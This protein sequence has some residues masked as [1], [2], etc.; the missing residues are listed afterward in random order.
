VLAFEALTRHDFSEFDIIGNAVEKR[1]YKLADYNYRSRFYD[2]MILSLWYGGI[3]WK[4]RALFAT[5]SLLRA[6]TQKQLGSME[7]ALAEVCTR[8]KVDILAV[9]NLAQC[10]DVPLIFAEFTDAEQVTYYTELF[11]KVIGDNG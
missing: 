5:A 4:S 9:K 7:I 1:L 3:Y 2:M 10:A 8:L 6:E 11:M